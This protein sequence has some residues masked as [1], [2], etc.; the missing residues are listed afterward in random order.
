VRRLALW[1]TLL[2]LCCVGAFLL[3]LNGCG[4][5]VMDPAMGKIQHVVI[6]FQENRTPDNLFQDPNLIAAGADI[7]SS[8]LNS[9]GQ[10]IPLSQI[11]L[12]TAGTNPDYYDLSHAHSAFVDMCN[13]NPSTGQC[14]MDGADLIP[15]MCR[16]GVSGCPP[17][18]AAAR[19]GT[20]SSCT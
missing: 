16:K 13:L 8:G 9:K 11:D 10:I 5:G 19:P 1:S 7:A 17:R 14:A 4:G 18:A 6:L 15:V 3:S 20:R 12:G 2:L